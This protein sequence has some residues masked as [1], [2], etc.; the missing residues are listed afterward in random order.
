MPKPFNFYSRPRE[1]RGST[2]ERG[3]TWK[4]QKARK[5]FLQRN[6]LC[7]KCLEAGRTIAATDVDHIVPHKGDQQLFWDSSNW[8]ALCDPDP[9]V[10]TQASSK[11][12]SE[13][14]SRQSIPMDGLNPSED[15]ARMLTRS[16]ATQLYRR[17]DS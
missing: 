6:L 5:T 16:G 15:K 14:G 4:W 3:Y 2:R 7:V 17:D 8:Q 12:K 9:C 10:A 13:A 11:E 1:S